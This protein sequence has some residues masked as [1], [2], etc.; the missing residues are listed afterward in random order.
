MTKHLKLE[1]PMKRKSESNLGREIAKERIQIRECLSKQME[2]SNLESELKPHPKPS[3][4]AHI[5]KPE[6]PT[7][8]DR[9]GELDKPT[10]KF[11]ICN[12]WVEPGTESVI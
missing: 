4:T 1:K 9:G 2:R 10:W 7:T 6:A 12:Y 11:G 8:T 5:A 3:S